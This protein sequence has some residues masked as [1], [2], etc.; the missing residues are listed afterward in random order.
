MNLLTLCISSTIILLGNTT[1][2]IPFKTIVIDDNLP[3]AYQAKIVDINHDGRPDIAALG[4]GRQSFVAWYENPTWQRRI[5]SSDKTTEHIDLAFYDI[6]QNGELELALASDFQ[7]NQTNQG[8]QISWLKRNENLD[9][10]WKV[11]PIHAEPTAHRIRWIDIDGDGIK[12]LI[13][14]PVVGR[15]SSG[16]QY[17]QSPIRLLAYHIPE[18]PKSDKWPITVI[19][20]S[21]HIAHGLH[22]ADY[23]QDKHQDILTASLEGITAFEFLKPNS[24]TKHHLTQGKPADDSRPGSSEISVGHLKG[25]TTF[26][27]TIDPWHGHQ[28]SV[29]TPKTDDWQRH[30]IDDSYISGHAVA[31]IDE[32]SDG[33]DEILAGY[34]GKGHTLYLYKLV[35]KKWQR[36][37][38][39]NTVAVQGISIGDINNDGHPDFTAAGGSTHN[40]VLYVNQQQ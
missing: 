11:Y 28:V 13:N 1:T 34:R 2:P 35:D 30:V 21:L 33:N 27:A 17:D 9:L 19:D 15:G 3:R 6:D 18:N 31:C 40:V 20:H 16:P 39:D 7:L 29:Y 4:E 14:A 22:I 10:P 23:N 8:G 32:D 37:L 24:W 5:I 26:L 38:I 12:E 25:G 36:T